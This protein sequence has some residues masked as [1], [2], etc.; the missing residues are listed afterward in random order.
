[1]HA[2][3]NTTFVMNGRVYDL[4]KK[5]AQIW[6]PALGTLYFALSAVWGLPGAD[7]VTGTVIAVDTFLGVMLNISKNQYEASGAQYDGTVQV[8]QNSQGAAAGFQINP[9]DLVHKD[10]V[11]IKVLPA[12]IATPPP[13]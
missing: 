11:T 7:K 10:S 12:K 9:E 2:E 6:L 13:E 3:T 5:L 1:M 8:I 4:L